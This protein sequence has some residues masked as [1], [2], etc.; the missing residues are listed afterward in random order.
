MILTITFQGKPLEF[1]FNDDSKTTLATLRSNLA[2]LTG[3]PKE[4]QKLII[5]KKGLVKYSEES[6]TNELASIFENAASR[7]RVLLLGPAQVE[8]AQIAKQEKLH[9]EQLQKLKARSIRNASI[10]RN[11]KPNVLK[12]NRPINTLDSADTQYVFHGLKVLPCPGFQKAQE[13]LE[14]LASDP[15]VLHIMKKHKFSVGI[16]TELDPVTNTTHNGKR[17]GFNI[18][19][20][21]EISLRLRTD[22]NDG[23]RQY[24]GIR[25]VLCH[26]LT[27]N[28]YSDHDRNF[29]DL[30]KT[31]ERE[32]DAADPMLSG[33]TLVDD[34]LTLAGR[35][36]YDIDDE[37]DGF[38]DESGLIGGE[39]VLG[40][41]SS[42]GPSSIESP[43]SLRDAMR[44]AAESRLQK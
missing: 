8:V 16:L 36:A 27:H 40:G 44:K 10:I 41:Q 1:S 34:S 39:F 19:M 31:L 21:Q 4:N 25:K 22:S 28:V 14:R 35:N 3:V 7:S 5:P 29:W 20:G 26:E 38:Y 23:W 13:L 43:D 2:E 37:E 9:S 42:V 12:T 30:C 32:C 33:K 24:S 15:A 6:E 11:S 17:L 18:N